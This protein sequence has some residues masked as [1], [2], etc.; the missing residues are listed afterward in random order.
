M[1]KV[2]EG[3]LFYLTHQIDE[4]IYKYGVEKVLQSFMANISN[5]PDY[6]NLIKTLSIALDKNKDNSSF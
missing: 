4:L 3:E 1:R 6:S 5:N 2:I